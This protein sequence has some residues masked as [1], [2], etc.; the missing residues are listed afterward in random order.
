[1]KTYGVMAALLVLLSCAYSSAEAPQALAPIPAQGK[2]VLAVRVTPA[3]GASQGAVIPASLGNQIRYGASN[4]QANPAVNHSARSEQ[5]I[6]SDLYR[7][8]H[9]VPFW[10]R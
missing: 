7:E 10:K 2:V 8:K 3:N 1:M 9:E 4:A 6:L 5:E